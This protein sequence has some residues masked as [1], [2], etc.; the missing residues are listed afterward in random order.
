MARKGTAKHKQ[1]KGFTLIELL[2]VIGIIAI[3]AGLLL[4]A[5][6]KGAAHARRLQCINDQRQIT[7]TWNLYSSDF[8][9]RLVPN[10]HNVPSPGKPKTWVGGDSHFYLPGYTNAAMLVD[11]EFAA[12][13]PYLKNPDLYK[14]PMD[15]FIPSRLP[16]GS[17]PPVR[18]YSMNA[19][20]NWISAPSELSSRYRIYEKTGDV[21]GRSP[22]DLFVLMETHPDSLCYPAFVVYMPDSPVDGFFHYPSSLH[23]GQGVV[24]FADGHVTSKR[25]E[26]PRTR[27]P[28]ITGILA[29][30]DASPNNADIAWMRDRATDFAGPH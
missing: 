30:W 11:P 27:R 12:F 1:F 19:Y 22:S 4:P 14:C 2:V 20:L 18:S 21:S 6:S 13:A 16:Q 15:R 8:E 25:W 10:G 3:L 9:E 26:D 23:N 29:H 28:V 7:L 5:L 17:R 24:S